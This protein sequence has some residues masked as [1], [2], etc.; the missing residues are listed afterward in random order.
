MMLQHSASERGIRN[1]NVAWK[2]I[3]DD[4]GATS[5]GSGT[6]SGDYTAFKAFRDWAVEQSG[7]VGLVLPPSSG[8]A[9]Y[10]VNGSYTAAGPGGWPPAITNTPFFGIPKLI[11]Y[12]YGAAM[13]GLHGG[14]MVNTNVNNR[15][16]IH[17][18]SAGSTVLQ[19]KNIDDA[20][21]F[22]AGRMILLAG[23]D[24]QGG[25][26][27]P[28]NSHFNEWHRISAID[29]DQITL[30][31]PIRYDYKDDWPRHFEGNQFELGGLG[32]ATICR[33]IPAWDCEHRI[34]GLRSH[35]PG[36]QTYYFA[37]KA[38]LVDVR[39]DDLGW[40][41]GASEDHRIIAQQHSTS[42]MEADKLTT[43]ALIGEYHPSN[44]S[45]NIQ[46]SSIDDLEVRGGTRS[47]NGTARH[48]LIHSGSSPS[49][50]LG[51]TS[52]G[53]SDE[54]TIR[55]HEFAELIG[56]NGGMNYP[57]DEDF[58]YE[59]DGVFRY[60][61]AAP[62]FFVPDAVC[63]IGT[64][65]PFFHHTPF[66]IVS[67]QSEN[68]EIDGPILLNTTLTGEAVPEINGQ[69]NTSIMRHNA[70]N[71]TVIN[72]TGGREAEELSLVPPN[73]PYGMFKRRTL[74]GANTS[75]GS[76]GYLLG[77]L[78]RLKINV[79]QAYTG[80]QS[81]LALR[82]GGQFGGWI[83]H[84]DLT[85]SRPLVSVNLKIA[86]E[87]VITPEGV[88]GSQTGDSNLSAFTG[89]I[90]IGNNFGFNVDMSQTISSEAEGVR[91]IVT[92]EILTDQEIPAAA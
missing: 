18:V 4:Y 75:D 63:L 34:Y 78:V 56:T 7:W 31:K 28:P 6:A 12:G 35:K 9:Y 87:R 84:S 60:T 41:V 44:R 46:S 2:N 15:A 40:I 53:I 74:N 59:G 17:T 55:D 26:G 68:G 83:V 70:P 27:Y 43:S 42:G 92:I 8:G 57:L 30:T 86:G 21:I 80:V 88:T 13:N 89:G 76:M 58:T 79:T 22:E 19:L 49:I 25:W 47:I 52:Y 81:T 73:S 90:W 50:R 33:T 82:I 39:S 14:S 36:E 67:V 37:R 24:L 77:R 71:L 10:G 29:G 3:V 16:A 1:L 54:I 48:M 61:G 85:Q 51:P 64:N 20:A 69:T 38:M 65:S 5:G 45:I 72:C 62:Q 11:V 66:R 23:L 32:P 91:P